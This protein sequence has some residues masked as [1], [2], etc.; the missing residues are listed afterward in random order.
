MFKS[1]PQK[2]PEYKTM[3][4]P[5]NNPSYISAINGPPHQGKVSVTDGSLFLANFTM[6][7]AI[8]AVSVGL[9]LYFSDRS[10][11]KPNE[12]TEECDELAAMSR[13]LDSARS[14]ECQDI[15]MEYCY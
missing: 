4:G 11:P 13:C 9:Y 7:L 2:N 3:S 15:Y 10:K 12:P 1:I 8:I 5:G 6:I 14:H